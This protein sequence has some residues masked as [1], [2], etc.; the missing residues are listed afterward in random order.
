MK[1]FE[2]AKWIWNAV[3]TRNKD[4]YIEFLSACNCAPIKKQSFV[5]PATAI[6]RCLLMGN[7]LQATSMEITSIIKSMTN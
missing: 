3:G 5:F 4:E 2:T 1:A 6:I 7:L